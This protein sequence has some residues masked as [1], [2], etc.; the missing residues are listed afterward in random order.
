MSASGVSSALVA[1]SSARITGPPKLPDP[2]EPTRELPRLERDRTAAPGGCRGD[3][4]G[5]CPLRK[6]LFGASLGPAGAADGRGGKRGRC[7]VERGRSRGGGL[8]Q[9][10]H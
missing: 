9:R 2:D 6:P 1:S 8:R 10:R 5:A 3:N 7:F 4:G